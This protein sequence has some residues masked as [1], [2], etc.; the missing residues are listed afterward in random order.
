MKKY[1][2][3]LL[4]LLWIGLL[5][6][7]TYW[8]YNPTIAPN[9]F[10]S[11]I[12][13]EYMSLPIG[14]K[15]MYTE[16]TDEGRI[17]TEIFIPWTT[18]KIMGVTTR[19]LWE[20]QY[21]DGVL[22]KDTRAFIA[23]DNNENVWYFGKNIDNYDE[24]LY[25]NHDGSWIAGVDNALP[26]IWLPWSPKS[27]GGYQ[28]EYLQGEAENKTSIIAINQSLRSDGISY[29]NCIKAYE[30]SDINLEYKKNKYYCWDVHSLVRVENISTWDFSYIT[31]TTQRKSFIYNT[32]AKD[33]AI[34][35]LFKN[36]LSVFANKVPLKLIPLSVKIEKLIPQFQSDSRI[37]YIISKFLMDTY[38]EIFDNY[39]DTNIKKVETS[40]NCIFEKPRTAVLTSSV[41]TSI[42]NA[43]NKEYPNKVVTQWYNVNGIYQNEIYQA[44][45]TIGFVRNTAIYNKSAVL[46]STEVETTFDKLPQEIRLAALNDYLLNEIINGAI[47]TTTSTWTKTYRVIVNKLDNGYELTYDT[48]WKLLTNVSFTSNACN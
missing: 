17:K 33:D 45:M 14:K 10:S 8:A 38:T 36:K 7:L 48:D 32:T 29:T 23:Q 47:I 6:I 21:L 42:I 15:F 44:D 35:L 19:I 34:I 2:I 12:D 31:D 46:I 27:G 1:F 5:P 41:P 16:E 26:G 4:A 39:Q 40:Q 9:D 22:I 11:N 20:R 28:Q 43:H 30:Y 24:G 37:G 13:N 18:K 25:L 3:T